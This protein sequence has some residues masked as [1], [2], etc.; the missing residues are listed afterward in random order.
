MKIYKYSLEVTDEQLIQLPKYAQFVSLQVIRGQPCAYFLVD[1]NE[2][3][4]ELIKFLTFGT[5]H[6]VMGVAWYKFLGTY[7][8]HNGELVFHV[9]AGL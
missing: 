4:K 5:G 9:W 1:E 7:Q 3:E 2:T 8:L 6:D